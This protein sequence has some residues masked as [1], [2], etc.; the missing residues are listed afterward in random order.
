MVSHPYLR[1]GLEVHV[2]ARRRLLLLRLSLDL[3]VRRGAAQAAFGACWPNS[4]EP[5]LH[6]RVC[7]D[8][9]LALKGG[10]ALVRLQPVQLHP[11]ARALR[12]LPDAG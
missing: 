1:A 5:A 2:A 4:V 3:A 6:L 12:A 7:P 11:V 8:P 10:Q 9:E